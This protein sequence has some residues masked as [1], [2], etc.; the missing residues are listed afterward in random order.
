MQLRS[1]EYDVNSLTKMKINV[2][3]EID[4]VAEHPATK[5]PDTPL[6][7]RHM[8]LCIGWMCVFAN[9]F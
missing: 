1:K 2:V 8:L 4:R 7:G 5:E 6:K 9:T 3:N